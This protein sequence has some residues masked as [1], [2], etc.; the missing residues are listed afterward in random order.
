MIKLYRPSQVRALPRNER[1]GS[2]LNGVLDCLEQHVAKRCP[3][4]PEALAKD[5]IHL[6]LLEESDPDALSARLTDFLATFKRLFPRENGLHNAVLFALPNFPERAPL[7]EIR[8][9]LSQ[10]GYL[11][12]GLVFGLFELQFTAF[13]G[14]VYVSQ[15]VWTLIVRHIVETDLPML[16]RQISEKLGPGTF[17][18]TFPALDKI[19]ELYPDAGK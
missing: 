3:A 17:S 1:V 11:E 18:G 12:A 19:L 14:F 6:T 15:K 16:L 9:K 8:T 7:Q 10:Q 4:T 2:M 13:T 5:A